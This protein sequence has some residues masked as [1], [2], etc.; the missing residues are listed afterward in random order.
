M[1]SKT[2]IR[3]WTEKCNTVADYLLKDE[4]ADWSRPAAYALSEFW[5]DYT[6]QGVCDEWEFL[7]DDIMPD[8]V[9]LRCEFSEYESPAE[10]LE[11]LGL[12]PE[13]EPDL[14]SGDH[15]LVLR[16]E[17]EGIILGY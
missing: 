7:L 12:D 10:A 1:Q 15:G 4:Y 13:D 6:Q 17:N 9:A 8:R 16:L 14:M 3:V 5:M 2:K 11:D